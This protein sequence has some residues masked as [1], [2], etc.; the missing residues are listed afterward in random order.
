MRLRRSLTPSGSRPVVSRPL[1]VLA[2]AALAGGLAPAVLGP[3][4]PARAAAA[5]VQ[6]TEYEYNGS[7]FAE[8][9]N[10]GD[11]A[12]DLTGWSFD[13]NSRT[14]GSFA[15]GSIG[16]LAAGES[17]LI[18]EVSADAFRTEWDLPAR[19]KIAGSNNQNLGR[20]DEINIYDAANNLVDRL[21]YNDQ[22]VPAQG[23]RTD[24]ASAWAPNKAA[25]AS[26][27][28]TGWTLSTLN[29]AEGSWKSVGGFFGSPGTS[30]LGGNPPG[31]PTA[32]TTPPPALPSVR[33]NEV[34]SNGDVVGDWVELINTGTTPVA[35]G[36]WQLRDNGATNPS[37]VIPANTT[38]AP[39]QIS[40]FY[41]EFPPPGF[42]LGVDDSVTLLL[43]D[44]T[45]VVD[46]YAWTTHA[47]T[48][49]GRCPD[50][51]GEWRT[52][53]T[54]TRGTANACS[55]IRLNEVESAP[56]A[57]AADQ[58]EWVE[59]VNLSGAPVDVAGWQVTRTAG[60]ALAALPAGS[61]VP[62]NGYL[63]VEAP[64]GLASAETIGL[65]DAT[66][67]VID[68]VAYTADSTQTLGR[69]QDGV[70]A[71]ATTARPT[72][73][74]VNVCAGLATK[75]WPGSQLVRTVDPI[76]TFGQDASGAVF[77]P[78]DPSVL[79]IAQ[80][81]AG[82]LVKM[83]ESGDGYVPAPGYSPGRTPRYA[84]GTGN[85]DTEGI[86]IGPDGAV[87]LAAE[88][89]NASSGISRNTVL[90]YNPET[91]MN[92]TD[93]WNLNALLP[94]VG[95]NLGLEG[96]TFIP[97]S[98]LTA[99]GLVDSSTGKAYRP[100]DYPAHGSGL[101]VVGVE[102][103]GKLYFFALDQTS[104][105]Q[106][107]AH[108]IATAD[109]QL[110]TNAGPASVMD[111]TWDPERQR[112]WALCD[113]SCNGKFSLLSLTDGT[114]KVAEAYDRP[115][116]MA[117]L[118]NEGL[119]IAPRS[120]CDNG[121]K[122][123]VW[124]DDG[125]TDGYS[126]RAGTITCDP[127]I[128]PSITTQPVDASVMD[129]RTA[130]FT[131]D[132]AGTAPL[133]V[134]WEQQAPK[135]TTWTTV[136]GATSTTLTVVG[137]ANLNGYRYRAV[138]SNEKGSATS[139]AATLSVSRLLRAPAG[140][141]AVRGDGQ[142]TLSWSAPSLANNPGAPTGY[143][144]TRLDSL[145]ATTGTSECLVPAG[146]PL[147]C[148]VTGLTNGRAYAFTVAAVNAAGAGRT[149]LVKASPIRPV[150]FVAQPESVSV[151]A[152]T[153]FSLRAS[154]DGDPAPSL[155]WQVSSD[156][157][158]TW[159]NAGGAVT[160]LASTFSEKANAARSGWVYRLKVSQPGG[161]TSY[162]EVV[163]VTVTR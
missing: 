20:S 34:E 122:R 118:N 59:L 130:T 100:S 54:P 46:T 55:P 69:C 11:A 115:V 22:A 113:D 71:F 101:Y 127:I 64:E 159:R 153:V 136:P 4:A 83:I 162:S 15:I 79:W 121:F 63:V 67:K 161:A 126:L 99:G 112:L 103:T 77:D 88:R 44:G 50:G 43:A 10:V 146:A 42:G 33:L 36:G 65:N 13:D 94:P 1:A 47:A 105:V 139:Q 61:A 28:P 110:L 151:K 89:N 7:E 163:T 41:T 147:T 16:T 98:V 72:R 25:L 107:Q 68:S 35:I 150:T 62:A 91:S 104:A 140:F 102:G 45:T 156:G 58:S 78:A 93:E 14:P 116:G 19:I 92:A 5:D 160:G 144:V 53:T 8:I 108:L 17:A 152:G 6:I 27:T 129:E 32:G 149:A 52:T 124:T 38:L 111:V 128:A 51:S 157:G 24:V 142:V 56:A 123:V 132:A 37:V 29:D 57:G 23:P 120:R 48:T 30:T 138:V 158:T 125:D 131:V 96:V 134:R 90:R 74:A 141:K 106:E 31:K 133:V 66:G 76:G 26:P 97:D 60:P 109:P 84:D 155:R 82:T 86:T 3:A 2:T 137:K 81:K 87:Y 12:A 70:G 154:V 39:G 85:P 75:P 117:N 80:N 148:T 18:T 114:F 21:T 135:A 49:Y 95:A 145:T 119:A 73:G 40:A 9:T 143:V